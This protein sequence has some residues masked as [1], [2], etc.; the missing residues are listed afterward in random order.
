MRQHAQRCPAPLRWSGP[1]VPSCCAVT[2]YARAITRSPHGGTW[3]PVSVWR[4][5]RRVGM[6]GPLRHKRIK[7]LH[8]QWRASRLEGSVE[9]IE[10]LLRR[11]CSTCRSDSHPRS[12]SERSGRHTPRHH[13][14]TQLQTKL[15]TFFRVFSG[16]TQPAGTA[17]L[18]DGCPARA[19]RA[20]RLTR[21]W[22]S[23]YYRAPVTVSKAPQFSDFR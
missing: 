18:L 13:A 14:C 16:P 10:T 20:T 21:S 5:A 15:L 3:W 19:A 8:V 7:A 9:K 12:V 11:A 6:R 17:N 2:I 1:R 23:L 22:A 4:T